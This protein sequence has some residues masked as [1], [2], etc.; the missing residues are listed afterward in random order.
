MKGECKFMRDVIQ[1]LQGIPRVCT[2]EEQR[3][4][5]NKNIPEDHRLEAL[6]QGEE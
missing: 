5:A 1:M 2:L 4:S 6:K 3:V